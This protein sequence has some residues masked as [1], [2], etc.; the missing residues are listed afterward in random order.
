MFTAI[1]IILGLSQAIIAV[2]GTRHYLKHRS[3]YG[4]I[5]LA[6]VYGLV[7]DNLAIAAGSFLKEGELLKAINVPRFVIHALITPMLIIY[8]VGM[9]R[10]AGIG[11]A[12]DKMWHTILCLLST[13]MIALGAYFDIIRLNLEP[14]RYQDTLRYINVGGIKGPP[15]AAIVTIVVVIVIGGWLWR[16]TKWHWLFMG[17]ALMFI[18]AAVGARLIF[19]ANTGEVAMTASS[20]ATL[21]W[22]TK[23]GVHLRANA[24]TLIVPK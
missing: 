24:P 13:A 18:A 10:W 19:I 20:I 16:Q 5:V 17:S 12:Q 1:H 2:I 11:W 9:A 3:W 15:I 14:E 6:I 22:L 4:L 23:Q 7:Y 8:S 21:I